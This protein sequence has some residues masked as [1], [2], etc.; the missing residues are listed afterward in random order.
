M[1]GHTGEVVAERGIFDEEVQFIQKPFSVRGFSEKV[2][3][4]WTGE[5]LSPVRNK[6]LDGVQPRKCGSTSVGGQVDALFGL[7]AVKG[8][9]TI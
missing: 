5:E 8:T 9:S 6:P 7:S 4:Y 3:G 1:S 2:W